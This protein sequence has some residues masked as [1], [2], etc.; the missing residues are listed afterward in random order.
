MKRKF[1]FILRNHKRNQNKHLD[2]CLLSLYLYNFI[3]YTSKF[4]GS[5]Y[6]NHS[7]FSVILI[8]GLKCYSTFVF[9]L[10]LSFLISI[11][12]YKERSI[13]ARFKCI[14]TYL[15]LSNPSN[16]KK[17]QDLAYPSL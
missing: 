8:Q 12:L 3:I 4:N 11:T 14:L 2:H 10:I 15:F 5:K 1:L 9:K 16:E 7:P 6:L 17:N 13:F